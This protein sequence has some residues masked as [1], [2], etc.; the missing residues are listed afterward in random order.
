MIQNAWNDPPIITATL[1]LLAGIL[2]VLFLVMG[3]THNI[4][5][6]LKKRLPKRPKREE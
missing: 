4:Y 3:V 6:L 5:R 1:G 2:V